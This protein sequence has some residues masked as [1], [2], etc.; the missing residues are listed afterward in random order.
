VSGAISVSIAPNRS[1]SADSGTPVVRTVRD[2]TTR[3]RAPGESRRTSRGST[4]STSSPRISRGTPGSSTATRPRASSIHSPGAVPRGLGRMVAPSGTSAW[5]RLTAGIGRPNRW[6]RA[7]I[8]A[9]SPSSSTSRLPNSSATTVFVMSSRVGPRPPVVTKQPV[10]SSASATAAR[11]A[12]GRSATVTRRVISAPTA[13]RARPS[14]AAFES[15][16][17]PSSSSVPMVTISSFTR[18]L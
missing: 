18:G 4:S 7:A 9:S 10:R 12:S 15:T 17:Y 16:V 1:A 3:G 14:S 8:P 2:N 5:V 13:A 6:N 11:I